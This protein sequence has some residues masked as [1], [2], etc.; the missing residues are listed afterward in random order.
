M[1]ELTECVFSRT[2]TRSLRENGEARRLAGR[3]GAATA[4]AGNWN[5]KVD[6]AGGETQCQLIIGV[7]LANRHLSTDGRET[8]RHSVLVPPRGGGGGWVFT[9]A[10]WTTHPLSRW[11]QIC[12]Y[13]STSDYQPS[14]HEAYSFIL[15]TLPDG[16]W[17][18]SVIIIPV[19]SF[20]WHPF[21]ALQRPRRDAPGPG[22]RV[23]HLIRPACTMCARSRSRPLFVVVG[24]APPAV[25]L[26]ICQ[27]YAS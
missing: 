22:S 20:H 25:A 16:Q 13:L 15:C 6:W 14:M 27:V 17:W 1:T 2:D 11:R 5:W 9:L 12:G 10:K 23:Q 3:G 4:I 8:H 21:T 7:Y 24:W 18:A 26:L 19:K